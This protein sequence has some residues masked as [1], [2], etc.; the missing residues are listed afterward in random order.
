MPVEKIIEALIVEVV[1]LRGR[2]LAAVRPTVARAL[3]YIHFKSL[4]FM[5]SFYDFQNYTSVQP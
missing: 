1:L 4:K 5:A 2:R 3:S